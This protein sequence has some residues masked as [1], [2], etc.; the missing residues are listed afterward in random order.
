MS[1]LSF[2]VLFRALSMSLSRK[3]AF[4]PRHS[5]LIALPLGG[6][7]NL[8]RQMTE[9]ADE[10]RPIPLSRLPFP[11]RNHQLRRLGHHRFCMSFRDVEDLLAQRG[12][13]VSYEAIR[14]WCRKFGPDY[15]RRLK[16]K[17]GWAI[18]GTWTSCSFESTDASNIFGVPSTRTGT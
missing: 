10:K 7:V 18:P 5:I 4:G 6:I 2:S 17:L 12:I 11:A 3:T 15:A 13:I 14:R 16:K 1:G 8:S 9:S